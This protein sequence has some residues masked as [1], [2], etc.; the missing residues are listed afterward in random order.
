MGFFDIYFSTKWALLL[1]IIAYFLSILQIA[2]NALCLKFPGG[3]VTQNVVLLILGCFNLISCVVCTIFMVIAGKEEKLYE[4]DPEY[5][6]KTR[7]STIIFIVT[8]LISFFYYLIYFILFFTSD[9]T[10]VIINGKSCNC[11]EY[12][13]KSAFWM[14][15]PSL[16]FFYFHINQMHYKFR[17]S[18]EKGDKVF[19]VIFGFVTG[20]YLYYAI[21]YLIRKKTGSEK[22]KKSGGKKNGSGKKNANKTGDPVSDAIG[23]VVSSFVGGEGG[24]VDF[25]QLASLASQFLG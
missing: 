10:N 6:I 23:N 9:F 21:I 4:S 2:I 3:N 15:L 13:C 22:G 7:L 18:T 11:S 19:Q 12:G 25:S 8:T 17:L 1:T 20:F 24:N 14:A 16:F 5:N